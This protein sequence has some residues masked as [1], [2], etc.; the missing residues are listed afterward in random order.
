MLISFITT[1]LFLKIYPIV[2]EILKPFSSMD[3]LL[4]II[5]FAISFSFLS[6][7]I[8]LLDRFLLRKKAT[9]KLHLESTFEFMHPNRFK[10]SMIEE[11]YWE[12]Y[13]TH[14]DCEIQAK[15]NKRL[16]EIEKI[17]F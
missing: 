12:E 7:A 15:K 13:G 3:L 1:N 6:G 16:T 17:Y 5:I 4:G 11:I 10:P 9:N 14:V 2:A 8:L